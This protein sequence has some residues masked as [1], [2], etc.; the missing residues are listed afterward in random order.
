MA[1]VERPQSAL[2]QPEWASYVDALEHQRHRLLR[3]LKKLAD[4]ADLS[5]VTNS[6]MQEVSDLTGMTWEK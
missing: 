3:A 5:L 2:R 6:L 4:E 1:K